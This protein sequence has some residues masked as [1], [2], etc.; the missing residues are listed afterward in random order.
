MYT[1]KKVNIR[2]CICPQWY[3]LLMMAQQ[4]S[5]KEI[6]APCKYVSYVSS[7]CFELDPQGL[8]LPEFLIENGLRAGNTSGRFSSDASRLRHKCHGGSEK[9]PLM[10]NPTARQCLNAP[11]DLPGGPAGRWSAARARLH[12]PVELILF[13]RNLKESKWG[14]SVAADWSAWQPY[15]RQ[16]ELPPITGSCTPHSVQAHMT[17]CL[18]ALNFDGM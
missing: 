2:H 16:G 9:R 7:R 1:P 5:V 12:I 8:E 15:V 18:R 11:C 3:D 6:L 4:L 10:V 13:I 17:V 14:L